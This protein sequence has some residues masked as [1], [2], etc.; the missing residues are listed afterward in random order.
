[1]YSKLERFFLCDEF[2]NLTL[3]SE[4]DYTC[5]VNPFDKR[6]TYVMPSKRRRNPFDF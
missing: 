4:K 1:M 5:A 6:Y 2:K 3:A